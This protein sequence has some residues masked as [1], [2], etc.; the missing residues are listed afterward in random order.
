MKYILAVAGAILALF[1]QYTVY[2]YLSF[3]PLMP[4]LILVWV[5]SMGLL[6]SFG[7]AFLAALLGG[8]MGDVLFGNAIGPL[9]IT[10]VSAALVAGFLD[11]SDNSF[12]GRFLLPLLLVAVGVAFSDTLHQV[13]LFFL[14]WRSPQLLAYFTVTLPVACTSAAAAAVIHPLVRKLLSKR[15]FQN[16]RLS[17]H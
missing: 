17:F 5:V 9:T 3:A 12:F 7:P 6:T 11:Y 13:Y 14:R 15:P 4:N 10:Y 1:I 16:R 8:L 2:A